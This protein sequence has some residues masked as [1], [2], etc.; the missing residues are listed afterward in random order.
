[1]KT[2][3]ATAFLAGSTALAGASAAGA[4][5]IVTYPQPQTQVYTQPE[6]SG[7]VR[8]G[9]LDCAI[10]GGVGYIVGS[11]KHVDCVFHSTVGH[12]RSDRYVGTIRKVGVDLGFTTEGRMVW[13]VIAP[14]AGYHQDSLAGLYEGA[15]VQA[16]AGI[17]VGANVLVGGTANSIQLQPVSVTGQIGLNAAVTGTSMTLNP[18]VG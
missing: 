14:T 7:G 2:I 17:G 18:V 9:Y 8:I 5:D 1:M 4:A 11:A 3:L 13:A 10:G 15:T 16:T 6:A 12:E